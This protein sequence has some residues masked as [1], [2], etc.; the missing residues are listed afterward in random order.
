MKQLQDIQLATGAIFEE[1]N[2]IPVSFGNDLEAWEAAKSGVALSDR[3]HW[4]LLEISD[5]D[6]LHFIHN[7]STNNIK[8]LKSGQ[9]CDT[10]F[11]N[12]TARTIDLATVYATENSLLSLNSP[13]QSEQLLPWLDKYLFPMDRV[14]LKD[15]SAEFAIFTLIGAESDALLEKLG[16]AEII[17]QPKN[18][19][20][21]VTL[22]ETAIR[23]AVGCGLALPGYTLFIPR[24]QAATIWEKLTAN[25]AIPL[26]DR[27][28]EKLRIT[29]GKPMPGKE[30]TEDYNPL[31]A[32]LWQ[33][34][35]FDKGCYIGQETIARLN[36]YQ[37]VKQR[38]WG[39]ELD[40]KVEPGTKVTVEDSKVGLLTSYAETPTG[41]FGLAYVRTKAGGV[42]LQVNLGEVIGELVA[43]PFLKHEYYQ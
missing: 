1:E 9:G 34:I 10:V 14:K 33:A 11:V 43:V 27:V 18:S 4:T 3:S 2:Q 32:G 12:S 19:H 17:S 39:V 5:D 36:T 38:L 23:I 35:S 16:I 24:N 28:W 26:G 30:L 22:A 37:G 41:H 7:Q 42:G 8:N 31:E 15:V 13:H 25:Q 21:V 29:Q 40:G 6:R 20:Q